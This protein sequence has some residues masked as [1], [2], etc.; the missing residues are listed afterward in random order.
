MQFTLGP[1]RVSA[2]LTRRVNRQ[3]SARSPPANAGTRS[4]LALLLIAVVLVDAPL[5][6]VGDDV[7]GEG[8][9]G[10]VVDAGDELV[11]AVLEDVVGRVAAFWDVTE[12]DRLQL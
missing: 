10:V 4:Q 7:H 11:V 9:S 12:V 8:P 6:A 1:A 2:R 3:L 5:G